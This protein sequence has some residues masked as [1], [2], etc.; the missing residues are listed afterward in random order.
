ME[1][2]GVGTLW[3][4]PNRNSRV[5]QYLFE[6]NSGRN[7]GGP[8]PLYHVGEAAHPVEDLQKEMDEI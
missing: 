2:G 3:R 6:E 7:L 4:N 8:S 5:R 1:G